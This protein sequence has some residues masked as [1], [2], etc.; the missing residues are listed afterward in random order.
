M[1]A[2]KYGADKDIVFSSIINWLRLPVT[3]KTYGVS[4]ELNTE[5]QIMLL[6]LIFPNIKRIGVLY[7]RQYNQEWFTKSCEEAEKMGIKIIGRAVLDNSNAM[8]LLKELL[9]ESD[10]FWL[11]PDPAIMSDKQTVFEVLKICD[12]LK[13]PIFSYNELF[14]KYGAILSISADDLTIARQAAGIA[15]E[16]LEKKRKINEKVQFPAGTHIT[17]NLKKI[18]EYGLKYSE[19]AL[20]A[21]NSIIE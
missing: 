9:N 12:S 11:I 15:V 5:M 19:D 18:K 4:N 7:S 13:I 10:I 1:L 21:V 14:T 17:L 16:V 3:P 8:A 2:G 20:G 6:R